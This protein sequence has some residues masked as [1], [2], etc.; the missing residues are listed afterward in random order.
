MAEKGRLPFNEEK[1][2]P[3]LNILWDKIDMKKNYEKKSRKG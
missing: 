3:R 2:I 1:T